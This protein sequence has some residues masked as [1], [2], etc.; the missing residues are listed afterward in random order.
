[1]KRLN[2][3]GS[4]VLGIALLVLV[5]GVIVFAGYKVQQAHD[6]TNASQTTASTASVPA[7]ISNT[8]GLQQAGQV[9]DNSSAQLNSS[10]DDSSM[11]AD[12]NSM[13]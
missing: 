12:L 11:N 4:H 6:K 8:A 1:M 2:Q 13:L 7:T 9:L 3:S 10:L 5:L